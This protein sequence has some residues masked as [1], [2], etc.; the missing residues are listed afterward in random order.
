M[1]KG[2][3][4]VSLAALFSC[5]IVTSCGNNGGS[6][7]VV[8]Y[9]VSITNKAALQAEWHPDTSRS[10]TVQIPGVKVADHYGVD[11][12]I[13]SSD[14]E[15]LAVSGNNSVKAL[16]PGTATITATFMGK[17]S[18][19]V[20]VT[21]TAAPA[22]RV[23]TSP[24]I[25]T[26]YMLSENT[27]EG[28][29]YAVNE[30][31][32]YYIKGVDDYTSCSTARIANAT[33]PSGDYKYAIT[34]GD[35]E[36]M[37]TIGSAV[38][39]E[40]VNIGFAGQTVSGESVVLQEAAFKFNSDYTFSTMIEGT[41]YWIGTYGTYYTFSFRDATQIQYKAQ[42]MEFGDPIVLESI[43]LNKDTLA[44]EVA[45]SETLSVTFNPSTYVGTVTWSSSAED[46]AIVDTTGKVTGVKAGEAKITATCDG[47]SAE[48]TVTVTGE[49]INHG[50]EQNPLTVAEAKAVLDKYGN[51]VLT[52]QKMWVQ[53]V[54][55][56]ST[57]ENSQ[58]GTRNIFLDDGTEGV[59]FEFYSALIDSKVTGVGTE[60]DALKGYTVK[61]TGWGTLFNTTYELTNKDKSGNYDN[62]VVMTA[63]KPV[64]AL[65]DI[66]LSAKK[67]TIKVDEELAVT[68]SPDPALADL[69]DDLVWQADGTYVELVEN[70]K[71][72]GKAVGN[73]S[74]TVS[75]AKASLSKTLNITVEEGAIVDPWE[76]KTGLELTAIAD[77][78]ESTT[79]DVAIIGK[80][81]ELE[82]TDYG[83]ANVTDQAGTN[84]LLVYGI[85][86]LNGLVKYNAMT[87]KPVKDD[88]VILKGKIKTYQ[89]TKEIVDGK[90]MQINGE[91]VVAP[92]LEGL[93]PSVTKV[94]IE[95]GK[96]SSKITVGPK[97]AE[98]ILSG[99]VSWSSNDT[100]VATV[101]GGVVTGVAVGTTKV[102]ATA[103]GVYV[104]IDVEVKSATKVLAS[105][106][107]GANGKAEHADGSSAATYT[108]TV[109]EYTLNISDGTMMYTGARDAKGN[110][111]IKFGT[112]K[113]AASCKIAV[114]KGVKVVVYIGGYKANDAKF[115]INGGE[116]KTVTAHS[117]DGAYEGIVCEAVDGYVT[118]ASTSGSPRLMINTIEFIEA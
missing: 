7:P 32:G 63:T 68:V 84:T 41:E 77:L 46:V 40:H 37:K 10:V 69:P 52:T 58:Y 108:E 42:F 95:V 2:L 113:A 43:S 112:S 75:S 30:M 38:T 100:A 24:V 9:E 99:D 53:G 106:A 57:A 21:I 27:I 39:G 93:T 61:G 34:L 50:T 29:K 11:L 76:N 94:E 5:G 72:K 17:F 90:V 56:S 102:K 26:G 91:A 107:L 71:V 104:E 109:G 48:C 60:A 15:I 98:A 51:K 13:T 12:F 36:S 22:M 89:G 81:G 33:N 1:K 70:G 67:T 66:I 86:S 115:T 80:L 35:G 73:G 62:P 55:K 47:K 111:C 110:S 45:Q 103:G 116:E 8:T 114:P 16:K 25:G 101:D 87:N 82:N 4:A 65:D 6:A 74:V 28:R 59:G 3:I 117:N 18:D 118:V 83:K 97:P 23:V 105:F 54:V 64:V 19:S 79:E 49:V 92:D 85:R 88:V 14:T 96:T 44:L 20:E 78:P 31:S